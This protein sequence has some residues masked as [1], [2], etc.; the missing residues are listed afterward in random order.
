MPER[1]K[2]S[3]VTY[4]P[5]AKQPTKKARVP[6]VRPSKLVWLLVLAGLAGVV[7]TLGT[8]HLRYIYTYTGSR[9]HPYYQR[10]EYAGWDSQIFYP[11]G[12]D[13]PVIRFFPLGSGEGRK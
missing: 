2:V 1:M 7:L 13:C 11:G 12:G 3:G 6:L 4:P 5:A 8:P 10:C 9:E